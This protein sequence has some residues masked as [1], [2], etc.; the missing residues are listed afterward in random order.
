LVLHLDHPNVVHHYESFIQE[1]EKYTEE[2]PRE[3]YVYI[4]MDYCSGGSMENELTKAYLQHMGKSN[5]NESPI[6]ITEDVC[7]GL[8]TGY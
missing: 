4:V 8:F 3:F 2:E 7:L 1:R 5:P 6:I